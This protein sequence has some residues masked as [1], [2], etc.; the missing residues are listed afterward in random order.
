MQ[1]EKGG[2]SAP[3]PVMK[4]IKYLI[5]ILAITVK[6]VKTEFDNI[7]KMGLKNQFG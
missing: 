2:H 4:S 6:L 1:S 7:Y 5:H 3:A